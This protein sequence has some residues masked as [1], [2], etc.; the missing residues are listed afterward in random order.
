MAAVILLKK[1]HP[2]VP[3]EFTQIL[4]LVITVRNYF[5]KCSTVHLCVPQ[6]LAAKRLLDQ[7]QQPYSYLIE[8]VR[9]RDAQISIM[10]ENITS[11]EDNVRYRTYIHIGEIYFSVRKNLTKNIIYYIFHLLIH[12]SWL[13]LSNVSQPLGVSCSIP[14]CFSLFLPYKPALSLSDLVRM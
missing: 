3:T 6:L 8:S 14:F 7:T 1:I 13:Y 11:L 12:S 9:Q 10:K 2:Q 5:C 4:Y